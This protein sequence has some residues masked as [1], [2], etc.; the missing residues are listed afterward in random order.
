MVKCSLQNWQQQKA[1]VKF[2]YNCKKMFS[3]KMKIL[4][5]II[6]I[7]TICRYIYTHKSIMHV[8]IYIHINQ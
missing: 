6:H 8:D 2:Q 3:K 1:A 4:L 7:Y 5:K